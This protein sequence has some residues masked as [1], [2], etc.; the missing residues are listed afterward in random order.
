LLAGAVAVD[1][2]VVDPDSVA[3]EVA[4]AW[5]WVHPKYRPAATTTTAAAAHR[6]FLLPPLDDSAVTPPNEKEGAAGIEVEDSFMPG[7][8]VFSKG[9]SAPPVA[10]DADGTPVDRAGAG[11]LA[12]PV[13]NV[14]L[15]V[16]EA[17][18]NGVVEAFTTSCEYDTLASSEELGGS[19]GAT[20]LESGGTDTFLTAGLNAAGVA[21]ATFR[22]G[23]AAETSPSISTASSPCVVEVELATA[24]LADWA[25]LAACQG[26]D[27][28]GIGTVELEG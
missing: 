9:D 5:N 4:R 21:G 28:R 24:E 14:A 27:G 20:G 3:L 8:A 16:F 26:A 18:G 17:A 25:G 12:A 1:T 13:P 2:G 7:S 23:A 19:G 15:P 22:T 11:A 6:A 10:V